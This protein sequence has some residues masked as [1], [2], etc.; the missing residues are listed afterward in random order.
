LER[1]EQSVSAGRVGE[2]LIP[3]ESLLPELPK[4]PLTA[5]E[6]ARARH[7]LAIP[8]PA[9]AARSTPVD[10]PV[11]LFDETGRLVALARLDR[12][13]LRLRPFLVIPAGD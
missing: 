6:A 5:D 8:W 10:L 1:I 2:V 9:D 12:S 7:G 3:L 11:R 4:F 13:V